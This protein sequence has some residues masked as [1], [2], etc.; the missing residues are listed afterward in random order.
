MRR[1]KA[2]AKAEE[3]GSKGKGKENFWNSPPQ[4][5]MMEESEYFAIGVLGLQ[6][7]AE[8]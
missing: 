7:L 6:L 2:K 8:Q 1:T 3:K 5:G 4:M